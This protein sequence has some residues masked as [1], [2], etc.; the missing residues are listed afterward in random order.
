M[1]R[2]GDADVVPALIEQVPGARSVSDRLPLAPSREFA[3][4]LLGRVGDATAEIVEESDGE[5]QPGDQVGLSGL[6]RRYEERLSGTPG[7]RVSATAPSGN[8]RA[9]FTVPAEPGGPLRTSLDPRLQRRAEQALA[10]VESASALVVLR[11]STGAVLVAAS[12]PG[13]DGYNTA[14]FGQYAPGST[15]K[16]VSALALLRSGLDPGSSL[17]CPPRSTVDGKEFSNYDGYPP[18]DLGRVPLRRALASSCN[19]AFVERRARAPHARLAPAAAALGLGVDHDVGYPAY[20]GEVPEPT[21]QTQAAADLIGQGTV[22]A[23][24]LAMAAVIASVVAGEAV[25]P[26]LLPGVEPDDGETPEVEQPLQP[27]E[28]RAL[29][30]MLRLVVADGTAGVLAEVPGK[31]VLAKTGTA[32]HG[33]PRPDG[34]LPTHAWMVAAQGDLAVAAFVE[35]GESGSGTAGPLIAQVLRAR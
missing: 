29:R 8:T 28:A 20:F 6:Q 30:S 33:T 22:T 7:F 21:S 31:P 10:P 9:L 4:P 18:G 16:I 23:S 13:S 25:L 14:T 3:A 27:A 17:P 26:R 35:Q 24:P 2:A 15:F 1:L 12:G 11:P 34:S 32:E 5:I 19:T